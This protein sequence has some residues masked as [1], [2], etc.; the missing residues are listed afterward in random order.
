MYIYIYINID[1]TNY[2]YKICFILCML[3]YTIL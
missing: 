1:T 3:L 2:D